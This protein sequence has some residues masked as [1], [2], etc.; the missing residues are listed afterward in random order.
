MLPANFTQDGRLATDRDT[1]LEFYLLSTK[2]MDTVTFE[3][4][5]A[6]QAEGGR[7]EFIGQVMYRRQDGTLGMHEMPG[8]VLAGF[9]VTGFDPAIAQYLSRKQRSR[10]DFY[11]YLLLPFQAIGGEYLGLDPAQVVIAFG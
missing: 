7:L 11:Q 10:A 4:T 5:D 6:S 2:E 9:H 3:V 1:G 8:A